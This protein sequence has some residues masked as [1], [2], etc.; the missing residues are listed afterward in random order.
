MDHLHFNDEEDLDLDIGDHEP[1]KRKPESP[2]RLQ[3]LDA[4]RQI[5]YHASVNSKMKP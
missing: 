1:H 5:H 3:K 4:S 2:N